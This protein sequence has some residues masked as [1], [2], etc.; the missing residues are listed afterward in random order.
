MKI[1][2][3]SIIISILFLSGY[4]ADD[5]S[6]ATINT[7]CD[8][9]F[10]LKDQYGD[11]WNNATMQV[12]QNGVVV[13]TLGTGFTQGISYI[14]TVSLIDGVGFELIWSSGGQWPSECG[15]KIYD[16]NDVLL[17]SLVPG[18]GNTLLIGTILFSDI[19]N[20]TPLSCPKPVNLT[21]TDITQTSAELTWTE[22]GSASSWQIEYGLFGFAPG[23]GTIITTSS[24]S[25]L[26]YGLMV[27]TNYQFYVR[28]FC[29][30]DFS[31]WNGPYSFKTQCLPHALPF[32]EDFETFAPC[33]R[34]N[35]ID[36]GGE[37]WSF[38]NTLNYTPN[39]IY[40]AIHSFG[41][42]GVYEEALFISP[43]LI[44]PAASGIEME[45][46][47]FNFD[48]NIYG[49]NSVL[50][51]TDNWN[52][53]NVLWSPAAVAEQMWEQVVLNLSQYAGS[54][55][56]IGF[57][58]QG[59]C[60]HEWIV[61]DVSVYEIPPLKSLH[62]NLFLEGLFTDSVNGLMNKAQNEN[63][64]QYPG[65]VADVITIELRDPVNTNLI[66]YQNSNVMLTTAGY[67][68]LND[69]PVY[70]NGNY[71]IVTKHRNSLET[72]SAAP[73]S[74]ASSGHVNYS[75]VT[76]STQAYGGN[77][78]SLGGYMVIYSG[79]VNGDGIID[80]TDMLLI[81]NLSSGYSIGY[82]NE[83]VNGD[84]LIDG[85]DMSFVENNS[86]VYIQVMKP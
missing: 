22:T 34:S 11:G 51:S 70:L 38:V 19:A 83:D 41:S 43:E 42:I 84:G 36:G 50:I 49:Q 75:F 39:G 32:Y 72:W 74:F 8:Y 73:V 79:D 35:N 25:E 3:T 45:F 10:L 27:S 46:W 4:A 26:I 30:P 28:S 68:E 60:A 52:S 78:K 62:V 21:A 13:A 31:E 63:G 17:Y 47:T 29:D 15:I 71:Y 81:D 67:C 23:S 24:A 40:S 54:T 6:F 9:T 14:Q 80:G 16:P 2:L 37:T 53:Y 64:S 59:Q 48:A 57:L 85:T 7:S 5:R 12:R 65:D 66:L 86:Q 33:W 82:L 44:L 69:I 1:Y 18:A 76:S 56:S 55:V 61:D 20:C 77:M 58:Y